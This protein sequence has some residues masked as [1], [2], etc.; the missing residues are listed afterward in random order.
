MVTESLMRGT[1][2]SPLIG[3]WLLPPSRAG[4]AGSK[5]S[6]RSSRATTTWD[7]WDDND[8]GRKIRE[9]GQRFLVASVDHKLLVFPLI[10]WNLPE[11]FLFVVDSSFP[12]GL[13]FVG[14]F[15]CAGWSVLL[16]RFSAFRY[17]ISG[18]LPLSSSSSPFLGS[19]S[20]LSVR[21]RPCPLA[22]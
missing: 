9:M 22:E 21:F 7:S 11:G 5:N 10:F 1:R 12:L 16:G 6:R 13:S 20:S 8:D 17:P 14:S 2:G 4:R 3:D 19:G 15:A 18:F